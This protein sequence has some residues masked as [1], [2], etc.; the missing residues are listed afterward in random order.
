VVR[1]AFRGND[2]GRGPTFYVMDFAEGCNEKEAKYEE[3]NIVKRA[4]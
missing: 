2:T 4:L 1:A 3:T